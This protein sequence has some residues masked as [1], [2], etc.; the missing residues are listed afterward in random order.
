MPPEELLRRLQNRP[1]AP[2]RIHLTDGTRYDVPHPEMVL[3]ARRS[4]EI[5]LPNDPAQPIADRVVTVALVHIVRFEPL[6]TPA[7]TEEG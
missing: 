1:F 6:E 3:P 5:G 7:G 4:L 2:F